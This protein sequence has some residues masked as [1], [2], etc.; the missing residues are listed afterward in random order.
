METKEVLIKAR[1]LIDDA[2]EHLRNFYWKDSKSGAIGVGV[3]DDV[4]DCFC[5]AGA[6]L[7]A[8]YPKTTAPVLRYLDKYVG[9]LNFKD[10]HALFCFND[11]STKEDVLARL[12]EAI[13]KL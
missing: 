10:E 3:K 12:D 9:L 6:I 5:L 7:Y 1:Q 11:I 13:A 8:Q 4:P 2:P